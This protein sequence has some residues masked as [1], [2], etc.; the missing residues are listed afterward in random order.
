MKSKVFFRQ[1]VSAVLTAVLLMTLLL[2]L[3]SPVTK[4]TCKVAFNKSVDSQPSQ[5]QSSN[6]SSL[7]LMEEEEEEYMQEFGGEINCQLPFITSISFFSP[8]LLFKEHFIEVSCPPPWQQI[9]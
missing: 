8:N 3:F 5:S 6:A 9:F 1:I 4:S 2:P 7:N